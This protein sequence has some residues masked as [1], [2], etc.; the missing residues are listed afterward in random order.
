M[1]VNVFTPHGDPNRTFRYIHV[2]LSMAELTRVRA[3]TILTDV[4]GRPIMVG[5]RSGEETM[6]PFVSSA[7]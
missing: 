7:A 1:F 2:Y 3:E 6:S 4:R 5:A